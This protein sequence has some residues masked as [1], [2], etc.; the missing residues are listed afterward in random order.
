MDRIEWAEL[1]STFF[2]VVACVLILAISAIS[3]AKIV[4]IVD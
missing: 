1:F 3:A 4:G 2:A